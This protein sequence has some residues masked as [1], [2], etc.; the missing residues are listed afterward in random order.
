MSNLQTKASLAF[1]SA[2]DHL[3]V[4]NSNEIDALIG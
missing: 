1:I 2:W 3:L 4:R